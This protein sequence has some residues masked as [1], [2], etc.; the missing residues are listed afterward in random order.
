M[1]I[2][3]YIKYIRKRPEIEKISWVFPDA[4]ETVKESSS[5]L[6]ILLLI[7]P[8]LLVTVVWRLIQLLVVLITFLFHKIKSSKSCKGDVFNWG[9]VKPLLCGIL[10]ALLF[11]YLIKA[12]YENAKG[13]NVSLIDVRNNNYIYPSLYDKMPSSYLGIV[14]ES[15]YYACGNKHSSQ[16]VVKL[17][18][19]LNIDDDF[20]KG[21]H[22][23]DSNAFLAYIY[24]LKDIDSDVKL[25]FED[26]EKDEVFNELMEDFGS[27]AMYDYLCGDYYMASE[28][29]THYF[30]LYN[31]QDEYPV[32]YNSIHNSQHILRLLVQNR[33][34]LTCNRP[35]ANKA[36]DVLDG[37]YLHYDDDNIL[38]DIDSLEFLSNGNSYFLKLSKYCKGL[39]YFY[40]KDYSN[41]ID[42][43]VDCFNEAE[44]LLKQY[45]ALMAI[46]T[47]FWNYDNLRSIEALALFNSMYNNYSSTIQLQYFK[48]DLEK[49]CSIVKEIIKNPDYTGFE[50]LKEEEI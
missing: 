43:F 22:F 3:D 30:K 9:L 44:G 41:A 46:R 21:L 50:H 18:K 37:I 6:V 40:N 45:C 26:I 17:R 27:S 5:N 15:I 23:Y 34:S 39:Y 7:I 49:Y 42:T 1:K 8:V 20:A 28:K 12:L 33:W 36:L 35:F 48:P 25:Y 2:K 11:N 16:E 29:I 47:A 19:K 13:N 31:N 10:L 32:D 38:N 24:S 4:K 14:F